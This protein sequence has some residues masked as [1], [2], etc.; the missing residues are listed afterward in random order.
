MME[1][2]IWLLVVASALFLKSL[3]M[4]TPTQAVLD[5]LHDERILEESRF[6]VGFDLSASYGQ[7]IQFLL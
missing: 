7:D 5:I 6:G 3:S 4:P 1:H 2:L